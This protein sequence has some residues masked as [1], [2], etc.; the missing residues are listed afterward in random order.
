M[1]FQLGKPGQLPALPEEGFGEAYALRI[2]SEG[3]AA[4]AA[5]P[6][7]LLYAAMTLDQLVRVCASEHKLPALTIVDWPEF[8]HRGFYIEGGQERFGHIVSHDYLLEQIEQTA[9]LKLNYIGFEVYNVFPYKS[10]PACADES[11]LTEEEARDVVAAAHKWHVTLIPSLQTLAQAYELVWLC[12]EG[13][14]YREPTAPG[15]MCPSTPEIY[16]FIKGLYRDLLEWFDEAPVLGV[17]CSEIDMQWQKRYC[18]KCQARLDAGETLRDLLI[19]HAEKCIQAVEELAVELDRPVRP[20]IWGDEFYM[21]G[22]ATDWVGIERISKD[23]VIGF[24]KYWQDYAGIEGLMQRGYDV[25]GVTGIYNHTFYFVDLSPETPKKIWPPM[26]QTNGRNIAELMQAAD[27]ARKAWPEQEF[28]GTATA[29]FSKHR[30]RAFDSLWWGFAL[31]S[32]CNWSHPERNLPTYQAAFTKAFVQHY[33]DAPTDASATSLATLWNKL[34]AIKSD[35]ELANQTLHDVV[36]IYDTQEAGYIGNSLFTATSQA[37]KLFGPDGAPS[38]EAEALRKRA[39]D[40]RIAVEALG[41]DLDRL[42]GQVGNEQRLVDLRIAQQKIEAHLLR[43]LALLDTAQFTMQATSMTPE[44]RRERALFLASLWDDQLVRLER[45]DRKTRYLYQKGDPLAFDALERDTESLASYM[46]TL[47]QAGAEGKRELL[48]SE[49]FLSLDES[50]WLVRG[51]VKVAD[52]K[53]HTSATGG[54]DNYS[55]IATRQSFE[56]DNTRPLLVE[57]TVNPVKFGIDSQIAVAAD[58]EG[59]LTY[60]WSFYGTGGHFATYTRK[61]EPGLDQ[62][63]QLKGM[64]GEVEAGKPW[65]VRLTVGRTTFRVTVSPLEAGEYALPIWDSGA[66]SMDALDSCHLL[67]ADV[68]PPEGSASSEWSNIRLWRANAA[69]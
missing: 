51:E 64:S 21:Y 15:Q 34:D 32:Q 4:R 6:R 9:R 20:L 7:G 2:T 10:F 37:A 36:G 58:E 40:D 16:P 31:N 62:P 50:R 23:T 66:Q 13:I 55:G 8:R 24:W 52:G 56:L 59:K 19:G 12:D 5:T 45:L 48:L 28:L 69:D 38:P 57:F 43:Q 1:T 53:L 61:S 60:R 63:W 17:G 42:K 47:A 14:P 27:K 25:M 46:R 18:P 68:E 22:P 11:T 35:L 54:W 41:F 44:V 3:I 65:R 67:F 49:D 33:Y 30:L 39:Q 29:S 26:D